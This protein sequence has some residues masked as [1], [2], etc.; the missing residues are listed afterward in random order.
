MGK[1][2]YYFMENCDAI[3]VPT[4]EEREGKNAFPV[5]REALALFHSGKVGCIF[6]TGGYGG[7]DKLG[8]G[9]DKDCAEE[10]AEFLLENRIPSKKLYWDGQSLETVG[11]F[12]FPILQPAGK[13]PSL[14]D[15]KKMLLVAKEGHMW[16]IKDYMSRVFWNDP[17]RV[18]FHTIPGKHN[19]GIFARV[20]HP[21]FMTQLEKYF[22][23]AQVHSFLRREHP[24]YSKGWYK[25]PV[26]QRKKEMIMKGL[27]WMLG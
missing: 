23:P 5:S 2:E 13:N 12:T 4:G 17:D 26:S 25:K 27:E 15:F 7:F 22:G 9:L 11:N 16:R 1:G 10:T 18:D 21:A 14:L 19:D 3:I 20:Y 24:F 8:P 6:V